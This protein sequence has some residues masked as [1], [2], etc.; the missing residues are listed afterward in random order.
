MKVTIPATALFVLMS[1]L[2]CPFALA[3][4]RGSFERTLQV[5][6]PVE[7]DIRSG[8]GSITVR[9]G[10]S[11]VMR[12]VGEIRARSWGAEKKVRYLEDNPPIE[13]TGSRIVIGRVQDRDM[14]DDVSISYEVDVPAD[15]S[16]VSKTGSGSQSIGDL[17]GSVVAESGSGSLTL[18]DIGGDVEATAGSGSIE[19]RS[20]GG[21]LSA[22]TGS[23]SIRAGG[24]AGAITSTSGSGSVELDQTGAGDVEI[25]TGSGSVR[26]HGVRGALRVE[27]GSGS[28]QADGEMTGDW[29]LRSS[30]G[31]ITVRLP[32]TAA[33]DLEA[34]T[35]SGRIEMGHEVI[36]REVSKR[37]IRGSAG[38]GGFVLAVRTSSGNIYIK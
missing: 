26:I 22:K 6:G 25:E 21:R 7:L 35:S 29:R 23:G 9:T 31:S 34:R 13:Q 1:A 11:D 18:G 27:T 10:D 24:V 12:I 37:E 5:A 32:G 19:V 4:A 17:A 33:F 38:G 30:S 3:D 36:V 16:L 8:S 14:L 28:I 20:A 2:V 15:T